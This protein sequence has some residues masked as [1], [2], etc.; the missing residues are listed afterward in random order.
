MALISVIIPVY[1]C[2]FFLEQC[3]NSVINQEFFDLEVILVNDG[4]PDNSPI[5]CDKFA[6][7]DSRIKVIHKKNS[8]ASDAKNM[9]IKN[10]VGK[11]LMFMDCDDYWEHND[12]LKN[13]IDKI[14]KTTF[15]VLLFGNQNYSAITKE[16]KAGQ[17]N[18]NHYIIANETKENILKYLF[19]NE[20]FPG[21]DWITVVRRDFILEYNIFYESQL[22]IEDTDWLLNVFLN[23]N[24]FASIDDKFYIY[25]RFNGNSITNTANLKSIEDILFTI[26]KWSKLINK[27]CFSTTKDLVY[28]YLLKQY[29]IALVTYARLPNSEKIKIVELIK[30]KRYLLQYANSHKLKVIATIYRLFGLSTSSYILKIYNSFKR[31]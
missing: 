17:G 22:K 9:A 27:F 1:N 24:S 4:S 19:D 10:A 21:A 11:Y 16:F 2:D 13:I 15:D 28:P 29:L 7:L 3:I 23:A 12:A 30:M 14:N 5:I 6:Q 18:Y 31:F 25:R 8:G 20:L 26:D